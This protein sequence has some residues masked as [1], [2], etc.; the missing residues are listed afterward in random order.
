[1]SAAVLPKAELHVH[2]EG[3]APPALIRWLARRNGMAVP[4]GVLAGED[5]FAWTGFLGFLAT[6]DRAA[7]WSGEA[8][9]SAYSTPSAAQAARYSKVTSR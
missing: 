2:L 9:S 5:R 6:Y 1:V 8:I 7:A 4:D 3:T